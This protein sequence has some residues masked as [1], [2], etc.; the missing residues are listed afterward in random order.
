VKAGVTDRE[1]IDKAVAD[2]RALLDAEEAAAN[3]LKLKKSARYAFR[4]APTVIGL[5][6]AAVAAVP[7]GLAVAAGGVFL[8]IG[9]IAVEE[10]FKTEK[11]KPDPTA[12]VHD[13]KSHFGWITP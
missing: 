6:V 7:L 8:S 2:M 9:G 1:S 3:N 5:A 10:W 12:F 11:G 13:V 4:I